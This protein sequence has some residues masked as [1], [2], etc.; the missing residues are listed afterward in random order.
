MTRFLF[1]LLAMSAIGWLPFRATAEGKDVTVLIHNYSFTPTEVTVP[2][3]SKVTWTNSDE[4][5]HTVLTVDKKLRSPPMD[6]GESFSKVYD[7]VGSYP[8]VCGLHPQMK[9]MV[10]VKP[11]E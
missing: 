10:V 1:A 6:T 5:P 7:E 11:T 4:T 9:G 3:G 2:K 8:Y